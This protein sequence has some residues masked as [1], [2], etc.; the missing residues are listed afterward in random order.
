MTRGRPSLIAYAVNS[1][2]QYYITFAMKTDKKWFLEVWK[3]L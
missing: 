3:V 2:V 1:M